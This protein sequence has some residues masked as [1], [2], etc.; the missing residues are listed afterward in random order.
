MVKVL[1][2]R[3]RRGHEVITGVRRTWIGATFYLVETR[4]EISVVTYIVSM[5]TQAA[6]VLRC[7]YA[8][9]ASTKK[10]Y[11]TLLVMG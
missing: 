4:F 1:K 2:R 9:Y 6:K 5:V 10:S 7:R 3:I 11:K 8:N